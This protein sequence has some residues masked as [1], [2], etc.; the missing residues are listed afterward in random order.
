MSDERIP[1]T[2]VLRDVALAA[3][4]MAAMTVLSSTSIFCLIGIPVFLRVVGALHLRVMGVRRAELGTTW[5]GL[6]A[7]P[8][9]IG[10]IG[11]MLAAGAFVG[12][13][14]SDPEGTDIA[15]SVVAAMLAGAALSP[16]HAAPFDAIESRSGLV[17]A[18]LASGTRAAREPVLVT[19]GRGALL[20]LIGVVP[21]V[22]PSIVFALGADGVWPLLALALSMIGSLI[23]SLAVVAHAWGGGRERFGSA[24]TPRIARVE[25]V[26][27]LERATHRRLAG[28]LVLALMP[29]AILATVILIALF[30][31]TAA[32]QRGTTDG[33][34]DGDVP[35]DRPTITSVTLDPT[36]GLRVSSPHEDVWLIET[37]D[38]GGAGEVRL[39]H[40]D[41]SRA[42]TR[43]EDATWS[44][45]APVRD[46]VVC[47]RFDGHGVRTDDGPVARVLERLGTVGSWALVAYVALLWVLAIAQLRRIGIAAGLD[48]PETRRSD[49]LAAIVGTLRGVG[50]SRVRGDAL[51]V[52]GAA[53]IDLGD[54][55]LVHLAEGDNA[56]LVGETAPSVLEGARVTVIATLP[57]GQGSPFRGGA[58]SLPRDAK[59]VFGTLAQARE[60]LVEHTARRNV[61]ASVPL[62]FVALALCLTVL[63]NL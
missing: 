49:G 21:W 15:V 7:L 3:G 56:L 38:G 60:R 33:S 57:A 4:P 31:P 12:P 40:G 8:L 26:E 63:V 6:L 42:F 34:D 29:A 52:R 19:T 17:A 27:P 13:V 35:L 1:F 55:G 59:L 25:Q 14:L 44:L 39:L 10:P 46:Y 11:A 28:S 22:A 36:S 30:T 37:A 20:G 45:C 24:R 16:L 23:L 18:V 2:R 58:A 62:L 48:A 51:V 9:V 61:A 5:L 54:R 47:T 41:E 53:Q 43:F 32:W 50:E